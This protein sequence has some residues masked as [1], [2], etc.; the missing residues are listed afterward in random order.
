MPPKEDNRRQHVRLPAEGSSVEGISGG[1]AG[2]L[3]PG[4]HVEDISE[5]GIKLAFDWKGGGEFPLRSGDTISFRLGV[6]DLGKTFE[7]MSMVRHVAFDRGRGRMMVGVQFHGLDENVRES[8]KKLMLNMAMTKL[9]SG[10]QETEPG[11]IA[12]GSAAPAK[13]RPGPARKKTKPARKAG[14]ESSPPPRR[15]VPGAQGE[16]PTIVR[17]R[18]Q[19][20]GEILVKQGAIEGDKLQ[21]FLSRDPG[22]KVP[23][24]Q[25]LISHGL[26]DDVTIAK[27]LAVQSGMPYVDLVVEEPDFQLASKLPREPFVKHHCIPLKTEWQSLMVAMAARPSP[28]V[29]EELE[30]AADQRVRVCIA[31]ESGLTRWLKRLY[32]YEAPARFA[33]VRFPVQLRAE[34]R[35]LAKATGEAVHD[36]V[37]AGITRELGMHELIIAGP[38]PPGLDPQR[39]RRESMLVEV[40]VEGGR[41]Q[42][43]MVLVCRPLSISSS[44]Y[45]GEYHIACYIDQFPPG[46]ESVWAQVCMQP[47]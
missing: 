29:L 44:G 19:F 17:R 26:V 37:A 10:R 34:Y 1:A 30:L 24:G 16:R 45:A 5:G 42:N 47:R 6:A 20:L 15:R 33:K 43:A 21:Q 7:V 41:L 8:L 39:I 38:L 40:Q 35:F 28:L 12:A 23:I 25:K 22:D 11:T 9:R 46:G 3:P 36:M 18:R 4:A 2:S 14:F 32:N 27:A 13:P 31:A